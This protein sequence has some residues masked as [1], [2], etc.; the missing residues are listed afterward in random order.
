MY[1]W[2]IYI[3]IISYRGVYSL[4]VSWALLSPVLSLDSRLTRKG[5][6]QQPADI[7]NKQLRILSDIYNPDHGTGAASKVESEVWQCGHHILTWD[8]RQRDT[9]I[10]LLPG[11]VWSYSRGWSYC[12]SHLV[13]LSYS[14]YSPLLPTGSPCHQHLISIMFRIDGEKLSFTCPDFYWPHRKY[15]VSISSRIASSQPAC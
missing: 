6:Q 7:V 8:M 1:Y 4:V 9:D 3:Y 2:H 11:M 10:V 14:S 5:H 15:L 12:L 13:I